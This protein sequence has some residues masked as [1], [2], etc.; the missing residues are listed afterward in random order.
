MAGFVKRF[1][2]GF[3]RA[4]FIN[5]TDSVNKEVSENE[6]VNIGDVCFRDK[7]NVITGFVG[8]DICM[9]DGKKCLN[10]Y[11]QTIGNPSDT[12]NKSTLSVF[13]SVDGSIHR[14][15][16]TAPLKVSLDQCTTNIIPTA[17]NHIASKKYVD[18][19]LSVTQSSDSGGNYTG[20]GL[21]NTNNANN[22]G[23]PDSTS[24]FKIG[25]MIIQCGNFDTQGN[26][27]NID[28]LTNNR[29]FDVTFPISFPTKCLCVVASTAEF[30]TGRTNDNG[31]QLIA[32]IQGWNK[33]KF[34]LMADTTTNGHSVPC[35]ISWIAIGY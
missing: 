7:D 4:I 27:N 2:K 26:T 31:P 5:S 22:L 9:K 12:T 21:R 24:Y 17:N 20:I 34:R 6:Y 14:V 10:T 8:S 33:S 18:D 13:S 35:G 32:V 29:S 23:N 25:N 16:S 30:T 28:K 1:L 3:V 15:E 19:K 11:I